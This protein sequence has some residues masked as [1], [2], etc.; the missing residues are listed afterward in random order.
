MAKKT[1][2]YAFATER[3]FRRTAKATRGFEH[4]ELRP[5]PKPTGVKTIATPS[6]VAITVA[7]TGATWDGTKKT[8]QEDIEVYPFASDGTIKK[9][10]TKKIKAGLGLETP[11]AA[12]ATGKFRQGIILGG[13]L[14]NV[15]C[16]EWSLPA[17]WDEE[18]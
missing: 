18:E 5:K 14:L 8:N 3:D 17:N 2:T 4:A 10:V 16:L 9:S 11:I 1:P 12:P 6:Y 15:Q 7:I 13:H